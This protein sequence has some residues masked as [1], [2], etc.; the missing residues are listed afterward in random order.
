[1][2]GVCQGRRVVITRTPEQAGE[3]IAQ[4]EAAGAVPI[5]VP[6]IAIGP[7][8]SWQSLDAALRQLSKFSGVV[9][10]STNGVAG[11]FARAAYL[12]L[13][14]SPRP[15]AWVCA[16]GPATA[17][18]L[19]AHAGF[20][21]TITPARAQAEGVVA[22]LA[23]LPLEG[24][25]V[26]LVGAAEGRD[27]IPDALRGLGAQVTLAATHR[28]TLA[29]DSAAGARAALPG[30]DAVVFTSPSTARNLARLLGEDYRQRLEGAALIAI[31]PITAAA[32]RE[33]GLSAVFMA[34]EASPAGLM[35]ALSEAL[36]PRA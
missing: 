10:T 35:Q 18:A 4:L 31:G 5:L 34:A 3:L 14:P 32:V 15:G 33:L 13:Q 17:E 27:V 36:A 2:A 12:R 26:L 7:P 20:Q 28:T 23:G 22:A 11:F 9:F 21:S 1:M 29:A 24:R 30:A 19:S 25:E 8:S 16:L 6:T